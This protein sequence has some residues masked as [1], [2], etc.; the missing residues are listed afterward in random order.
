MTPTTP[1]EHRLAQLAYFAVLPPRGLAM[2]SNALTAHHYQA[3][4]AILIEGE[5]SQGLWL[6]GQGHVKIYKLSPD[7]AEHILQFV[8]AGQ[9]FNDIAAFDGGPHHA[10][11]AALTRVTAWLLPQA[12]L[13]Q[14]WQSYPELTQAIVPAL[15]A[16][17]RALTKQIEDLA[18][19]SVRERLARFLMKQAENPALTGPGITRT[20]IAAHL[21]TT[22]QTISVVLRELEAEGAIQFDRHRILIVREDI[23]RVIARLLG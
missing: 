22:P 21:N 23:L 4:E 18:L 19:C 20:A 17:V 3:G 2:L 15:A 9:T 6:V 1:P 13:H 8:G 12:D 7:G 16:Q 11:A 10:N 5:A 14:V